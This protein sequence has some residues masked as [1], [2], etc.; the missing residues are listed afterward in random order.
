MAVSGS[1]DVFVIGGGPAGLAAAIAARRR[2]FAVMLADPAS[3][4]ADKACG[5]GV[6]PEGLDALRRLGVEI[7]PAAARP[8]RGIR[9]VE[10]GVTAEA[11]FTRGAGLGI[12]RTVLHSALA[13]CAEGCGVHLLWRTPVIGISPGGV[14]LRREI[15]RSRWIVGADGGQSRVRRWL[16]LEPRV[17]PAPRY[18][19][20]QHFHSRAWPD[21]VEVHWGNDAQFYVSR[22]TEDEACVVLISRQPGLRIETSLRAFPELEARLAAAG[23]ASVS[24]GALTASMRL[25][26]VF[27]RS[28]ALLGDASGSVDAI[29][30]QGLTLAFLQAEALAAALA[31]G[32]LSLYQ[33][34]HRR[35][36]RRPAIVSRL[37]LALDGR[38]RL[39]S[40]V[41]RILAEEPRLFARW[42]AMHSG[43]ASTRDCALGGLHLGWRLVAS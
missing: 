8:F 40:H 27:R 25:P 29:S 6:L 28:V 4:G 38:P 9:F 17:P 31:A 19:V 10:R 22:V 35:M 43:A 33:T 3:P 18:A 24:R 32:D 14:T 36:M 37:L 13:A 26:R 11:C 12:R 20:R 41:L 16:G 1:T 7:P 2:G 34:A 39:R 30:G 15:I 21:F 42:L 5:E 23:P